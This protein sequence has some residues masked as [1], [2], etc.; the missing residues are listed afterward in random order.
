[1]T[2]QKIITI[3]IATYNRSKIVTQLVKE[4]LSFEL[5]DQ[6]EIIVID[7]FSSDDTFKSLSQFSDMPN[8]SIYRNQEN[9]SRA[10]TQ[11]RYFKLCKTEFLVEMPD[12]DVLFK[13]GLLELLDL[14]P[15][16]EVDFLS[17][18]WIGD[19]GLLYP[20]RGGAISSGVG[21]TD[22][23]QKISLTSLREQSEHSIGCV[24][25]ASIIKYSEK[26]LLER[27][28]KNCA[29]AF[30]FHQNI[31]L[32]MAMLNNAKLLSCPILLGGYPQDS[33]A[34]SNF[35]DLNGNP[36]FSLPAVFNKYIG[37]KEFYEDMLKQFSDSPL[38]HE[39]ETVSQFH[40]LSLYGAIDDAFSI[41][42]E[43][44]GTRGL[45]KNFRAG[46]VRN[47]FNPIKF[48]KYFFWYLKVKHNSKR[49]R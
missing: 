14:L 3:C 17:T 23:V 4:I 42:D 10:R 47:V 35:V 19:D 37:L 24:F 36:Y 21:L 43:Q 44:K 12:D 34:S 45:V 33:V 39:L 8:V 18:R 22:T 41:S 40:N 25:R 20:G 48:F 29:L 6:I 5:N 7:D 13:D 32:C 30:F 27:L 28:D 31:V 26:Y 11:L 15:R 2:N 49:Y 46:T 1:M 16:L 38:F 9:L